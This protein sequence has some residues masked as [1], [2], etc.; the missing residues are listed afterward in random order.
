MRRTATSF[1]FG[2]SALEIFVFLRLLLADNHDLEAPTRNKRSN[3]PYGIKAASQVRGQ[4]KAFSSGSEL[5]RYNDHLTRANEPST[6]PWTITSE[7]SLSVSKSSVFQPD[8]F[9]SNSRK[10]GSGLSGKNLPNPIF[11]QREHLE[12]LPTDENQTN[13]S[14]SLCFC[15]V[16]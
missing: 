7:P 1:V 13:Q 15:V 11:F 14:K 16:F 10:S 4:S 9:I 2:S 3:T 5:S 6:V 12:T 8:H